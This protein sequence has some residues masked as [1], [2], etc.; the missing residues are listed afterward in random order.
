MEP[1]DWIPVTTVELPANTVKVKISVFPVHNHWGKPSL[2]DV[3]VTFC[4][5]PQGMCV[6]VSVCHSYFWNWYMFSLAPS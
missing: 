4:C 1:W 6:C 5:A 3:V 2:K